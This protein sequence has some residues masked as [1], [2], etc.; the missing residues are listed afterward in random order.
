MRHRSRP[1]PRSCKADAEAQGPAGSRSRPA[2]ASQAGR[3]G[4]RPLAAG[5]ARLVVPR[6]REPARSADRPDG[7]AERE[8]RARR[9]PGRCSGTCSRRRD[10]RR[11]GRSS[12]GHLAPSAARASGQ[13]LISVPGARLRGVD[14]EELPALLR[15]E[16]LDER[17][18]ADE[19][20]AL[21]QAVVKEGDDL[22]L[23]L[24]SRWTRRLER[25]AEAD[26][27][28]PRRAVG[29]DDRRERRRRSSSTGAATD[30]ASRRPSSP[31][32]RRRRSGRPRSA[33]SARRGCAASPPCRGRGSSRI[34]AGLDAARRPTTSP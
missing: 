5:P 25:L 18:V 23:D 15:R 21:E 3:R 27:Q 33:T 32:C 8:G 31:G 7:V 2:P 22:E 14:Q 6:R 28:D 20:L 9:E 13:E 1:G 10:S 11:S 30:S 16:Q 4:S 12:A 34:V 24:L 26:V 29:V 17:R 19:D